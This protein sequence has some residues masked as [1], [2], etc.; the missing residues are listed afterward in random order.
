[1]NQSL[2]CSPSSPLLHQGCLPQ[3]QSPS[4]TVATTPTTCSIGRLKTTTSPPSRK[5]V[6]DPYPSLP[7]S[8]NV[9]APVPAAMLREVA[10]QIQESCAEARAQST[11]LRN[12]NAR[13]KDER[14][15][16]EEFWNALWSRSRRGQRLDQDTS[17]NFPV[18]MMHDHPPRPP[19][20]TSFAG[21]KIPGTRDPPTCHQERPLSSLLKL[22][23]SV[24]QRPALDGTKCLTP[25]LQVGAS[26]V[27]R[28]HK[29]RASH[30]D[31]PGADVEGMPCTVHPPVR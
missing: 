21:P 13:L 2:P 3:V 28:G 20:I 8:D 29:K 6:G 26:H 27:H 4:P 24:R 9:D 11:E 15:E 14:R 30:R 18:A 23:L 22:S 10:T 1:M 5:L 19:P 16:R 7:S 12:E 17:H 25:H 31:R